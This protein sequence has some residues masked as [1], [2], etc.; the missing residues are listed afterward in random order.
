MIPQTGEEIL[1]AF[2]DKFTASKEH[3]KNW[4]TRKQGGHTGAVSA[5]DAATDTDKPGTSLHEDE[6][7]DLDAA[8]AESLEETPARDEDK[9]RTSL[10]EDE[11]ADLMVAL[12]ESLETPA[13]DKPKASLQDV[14]RRFDEDEAGIDM[15][16]ALANSIETPTGVESSDVPP[17]DTL[18]TDALRW[19]AERER[20]SAMVMESQLGIL[21]RSGVGMS[22]PVDSVPQQRDFPV[23]SVP[24][25]RDFPVD[26]VPQ[27]RDFPDSVP[28]QRD[29]DSR[30]SATSRSTPSRSSATS[31]TSTPSR[32]SATPAR[33]SATSQWTPAR[34]SATSQWTPA[35][36]SA[37]SRST[38]SR[39]RATLRWT[40]SRCNSA[41]RQQQRRYAEFK[42]IVQQSLY[43]Y[44]SVLYVREP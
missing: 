7:A 39:S 1:S 3:A 6:R 30:S 36:S 31:R 9:P 26:S 38:P 21:N 13:R 18:A 42:F 24:Q 41:R 22:R 44:K 12:A 20:R 15:E 35:R 40:P 14:L 43:F 17:V 19:K 27:Q 25:Q 23:D 2:D 28:Q 34:S 16:R 4:P 37:T 5:P 29:S 32:S 10:H 11:R 33:S 8:L